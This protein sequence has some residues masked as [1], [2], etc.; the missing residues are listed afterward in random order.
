M[1]RPERIGPPTTIVELT[2]WHQQKM[3]RFKSNMEEAIKFAERWESK[4]G[5][6]CRYWRAQ[7][8]QNR[9]RYEWHL[10]A[11]ELLTRGAE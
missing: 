6:K 7:E 8:T 10:S 11:V 1:S 9:S 2:K 4:H 3:E 5:S